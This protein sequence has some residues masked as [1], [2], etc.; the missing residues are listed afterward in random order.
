MNGDKGPR[1]VSAADIPARPRYHGVSDPLPRSASAAACEAAQR[2]VIHRIWLD[3]AQSP[4]RERWL[5]A[6]VE[7]RVVETADLFL[8]NQQAFAGHALGEP[9]CSAAE[10][11]RMDAPLSAVREDQAGGEREP[12][13]HWHYGPTDT[14]PDPS[15]MWCR[16]CHGEVMHFTEG[17][18]CSCHHENPDAGDDG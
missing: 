15:K 9:V 11:A 6:V 16:K 18:A 13:P 5:P 12:W 3:W 17:S 4:D 1:P 2:Q 10:L 14:D 7:M 8:L